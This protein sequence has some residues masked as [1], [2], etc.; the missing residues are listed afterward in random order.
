MASSSILVLIVATLLALVAFAEARWITF[1]FGGLFFRRVGLTD[2]FRQLFVI[3]NL[4]PFVNNCK[5]CMCEKKKGKS[6]CQN[7]IG[8]TMKLIKTGIFFVHLE[9][10]SSPNFFLT[11]VNFPT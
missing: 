3:A 7:L 6:V 11:Q 8:I 4:G 10:N 1:E 2:L 9:P 5:N